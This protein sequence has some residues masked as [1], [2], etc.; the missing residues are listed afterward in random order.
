M[1]EPSL[2]EEMI[3]IKHNDDDDDDDDHEKTE[4]N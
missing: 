4:S 1:T 3:T 2:V